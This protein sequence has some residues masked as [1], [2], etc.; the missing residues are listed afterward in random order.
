MKEIDCLVL[1][2]VLKWQLLSKWALPSFIIPK[3]DYTVRKISDFRELN[4]ANCEKTIPY[5]QNQYHIAGAGRLHICNHTRLKHGLLYTH[6][7]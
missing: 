4:K 3:K 7:R 5:P 2:G 1:I 6:S